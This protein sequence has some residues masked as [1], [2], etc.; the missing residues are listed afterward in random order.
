VLLNM[1]SESLNMT[2]FLQWDLINNMEKC[3]YELANNYE[4]SIVYGFDPGYHFSYNRDMLI[5][6][7]QGLHF[8][9]FKL[10]ELYCGDEDDEEVE[11]RDYTFHFNN[12]NVTRAGPLV[13]TK[14]SFVIG[15]MLNSIYLPY[16]YMELIYAENIA[17]ILEQSLTF[18][19]EV[20]IMPDFTQFAIQN[21]NILHMFAI[22]HRL[23]NSFMEAIL[24][25]EQKDMS[26]KE[27]F[28][29]VLLKNNKGQT[30]LDMAVDNESPKCIELMLMMLNKQPSLSLS[31]L[32]DVHFDKLFSLG[33]K[34]FEEYLANC[35][36]QNKI[37]DSIQKVEWSH[38]SDT[39]YMAY[40]TSFLDR[41]FINRIGKL[42]KPEVVHQKGVDGGDGDPKSARDSKLEDQVQRGAPST[43][44]KVEDEKK[45]NPFAHI[46]D[47]LE[48]DEEGKIN[49]QA[50]G[51]ESENDQH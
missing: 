39:I 6:L 26:V 5:D 7:S 34:I 37:M 14:R 21:T 11:Y 38:H 28:F 1:A 4:G 48:E 10:E 2:I 42:D 9:Y 19:E 20:I 23:L 12:H 50:E 25:Q 24:K 18:K 31:G 40:H 17:G 43:P 49:N 15:D 33:T 47:A 29:G 35:W 46:E 44:K 27:E 45:E 16:S 36:F 41:R 22:N 32:V 8:K 3:S 30:P 51:G 13:A